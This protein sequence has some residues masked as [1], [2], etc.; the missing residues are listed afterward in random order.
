[1]GKGKIRLSNEQQEKNEAILSRLEE[2]RDRL[3]AETRALQEETRRKPGRKR[4]RDTKTAVKEP[5]E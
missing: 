3:I 4:Q 1:M 5:V 2:E